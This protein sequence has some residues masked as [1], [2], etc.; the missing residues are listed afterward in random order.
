MWSQIPNEYTPKY[1]KKQS[2]D[3]PDVKKASV[4]P[5]PGQSYFPNPDDHKALRKIVD[6][7]RRALKASKEALKKSASRRL[8]LS[9]IIKNYTKEMIQGMYGDFEYLKK[10]ALN[11]IKIELECEKM[12]FEQKRH[13]IKNLTMK[14]AKHL[15]RVRESEAKKHEKQKVNL[16]AQEVKAMKAKMKAK[17]PEPVQQ[18]RNIKAPKSIQKYGPLRFQEPSPTINYSQSYKNQSLTMINP[19]QN[20]LQDCFASFQRSGMIETRDISKK[21]RSKS[22][23]KDTALFQKAFEKQKRE[24]LG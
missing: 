15:S 23:F 20:V 22:K 19:K 7:E 12:P 3:F 24:L 5:H 21:R 17:T 10:D 18:N 13:K 2:K 8:P 1:A 11:P 14:Q 9:L 16:I 4:V 6:V